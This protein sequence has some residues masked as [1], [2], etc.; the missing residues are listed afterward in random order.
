M[1][2]K[3]FEAEDFVVSAD[4]I[5]A[6]LWSGGVPT[7]ISP[8]TSSTQEAS[9]A[10]NYY[11]NVYQADPATD[12]N[13]NIQF[14]IAY[15]NEFGSGSQAYNLAVDGNSPT[16][17]I[18]GQFQ[19][20]V[21]GTSGS[22]FIYGDFSGS[23]DFWALTVDRARYKEKLFL[24]TNTLILT[25]SGGELKLTDNSQ[26][27]SAVQYNQAGRVYQLVSGSAGV[28]FT[29][30]NANGY[31]V[32]GSYGLFLP[33][34][35]TILLNPEAIKSTGI[36]SNKTTGSAVTPTPTNNSILYAGMLTDGSAA[37]PT[38]SFTLNSE[39]TITSDYVFVRARNSEFN[40]SANPSYI[41][42]STGQVL[43]D[44]WVSN[45]QTYMTT[46]GLYNDSN[47]LLAVAKLSRPLNKDFTKEALV[48]VKLDF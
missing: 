34:I 10:G 35:G 1:S 45:P 25:G 31:S 4:S 11:L 22:R 5:T 14:A 18:W 16:R 27:V 13:A 3:R 32:S 7:L 30:T 28:V 43:Y 39:E 2:F 20:L 47:E 12:S 9:S 36:T 48:R 46:V 6:T 40:Y 19:N 44:Y 37:A 33:D 38:G 41:T 23:T 15:G 8:F 29:G 42:G 17:T 21:L 26:L 24:G